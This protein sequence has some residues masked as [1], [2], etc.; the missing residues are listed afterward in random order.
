MKH[1]ATTNIF[2]IFLAI[3]AVL[4]G[5]NYVRRPFLTQPKNEVTVESASPSAQPTDAAAQRIQKLTTREKIA[6]LLVV[7]LAVNSPTAG[8]QS[9]QLTG[10]TY[11][12]ATVQ[13][14][15][16]LNPGM[17]VL[18]GS[19]TASDSAESI[20][21]SFHQTNQDK[22]P[23]LMAVNQANSR[24]LSRSKSFS[25]P[26]TLNQACQ[27]DIQAVTEK[28]RA[29]AQSWQQL[30][31]AMVLG[32]VVDLS[33]PGTV[34]AALGCQSADQSLALAKAYVASFGS[35]GIMPVLAHFPGL[36]TVSRN[37]Q[38][39]VQTA[40]IGLNDLEQFKTILDA[41]P[42][43]GVLTSAVVVKDQFAGKPCALS[44][45]CLAQFS[46]KYPETTLIADQITTQLAQA[47]DSSV[48]AMVEQ[49]IL[50]GNHFVVVDEQFS[51]PDIEQLVNQL[52]NAYSTDQQF[53]DKVNAVV[54][55]I[56]ALKRPKQLEKPAN[57]LIIPNKEDQ[58]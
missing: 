17:V 43:I 42:N 56:E 4:L 29:T 55:K 16:Q 40:N 32:P 39:T 31:V 20:V 46:T 24:L 34:S 37:P 19:H 57:G 49:A 7:Q 9:A 53:A 6:Q 15:Q 23:I 12:S 26:P 54:T 1:T 38:K 33:Q 5:Y 21:E 52:S 11:S 14:L 44:R 41:Y 47:N 58:K 48:S 8:T 45:E 10:L 18:I 50:A 22:W 28:W 51:L 27:Q 35:Y 13:Q 36:G 30:G 25:L 2:I 3:V